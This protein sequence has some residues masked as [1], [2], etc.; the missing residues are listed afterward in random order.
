[1]AQSRRPKGQRSS[2]IAEKTK[3]PQ[4]QAAGPS[5]N[6]ELM[7]QAFSSLDRTLP[8]IIKVLTA[9]KILIDVVRSLNM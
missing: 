6:R 2:A 5:E 1:M 3:T 7:L 4:L 8:V 9:I